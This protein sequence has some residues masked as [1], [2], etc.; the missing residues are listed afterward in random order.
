MQI[1]N[2]ATLKSLNNPFHKYSIKHFAL[3]NQ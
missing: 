2:M 3:F 1:Y